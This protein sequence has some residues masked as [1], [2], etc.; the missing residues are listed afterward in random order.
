MKYLKSTISILLILSLATLLLPLNNGFGGDIAYKNQIRFEALNGKAD[1]II[2]SVDYDLSLI[3]P[4]ESGISIN[5][6]R[7]R[8]N[9]VPKQKS[10]P[11]KINSVAS[12]GNIHK[13][14]SNVFRSP[15]QRIVYQLCSE[16]DDDVYPL[17]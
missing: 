3:L 7:R 12:N 2:C 4:A 6:A 17:V 16:S 10:N 1:V 5:F 8:S 14:N 13:K 11:N 9:F 15:K